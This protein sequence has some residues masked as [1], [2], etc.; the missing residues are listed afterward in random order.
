M[1]ELARAVHEGECPRCGYVG[2]AEATALSEPARQELRERPIET[3]RSYA[4]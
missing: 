3:R 2:W 4:V 1:R